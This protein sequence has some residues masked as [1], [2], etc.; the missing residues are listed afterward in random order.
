MALDA[1]PADL[2]ITEVAIRRLPD[3]SYTVQY[4][5]RVFIKN[6]PYV[7]QSAAT[8]LIGLD[9]TDVVLNATAANLDAHADDVRDLLA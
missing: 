4:Q 1:L 8:P 7:V 2:E 3:D 6:R 9:T 5:G